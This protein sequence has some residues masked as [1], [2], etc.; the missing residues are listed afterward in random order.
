[1]RFLHFLSRKNRLNLFAQIALEFERLHLADN[2]IQ[3]VQLTVA[4]PIDED[5]TRRVVQRLKQRLTREI[6]LTVRVDPALIGGL[7]LQYEDCI[8]DGS[9]ANHLRRFRRRIIA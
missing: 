9:F 1:M 8:I 2:A 6:Q 4:R 5:Q 3:K 7:Y